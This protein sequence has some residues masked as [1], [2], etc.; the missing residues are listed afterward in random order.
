[1]KNIRII[2]LLLLI[3][4]G[5][6]GMGQSANAQE[7]TNPLIG[8]RAT[9]PHVAMKSGQKVN[10]DFVM[11][12]SGM[13]A[14]N[15]N[16]MLEVTP[17]LKS[18]S[19]T[20]SLE[21]PSFIISGST[22]AIV[23]SRRGRTADV[24]RTRT[25][26]STYHYTSEVPFS[27]WLKDASLLL[28]AKQYG[29]ADCDLGDVTLNLTP[30]AL[31][32]LYQPKYQFEMLVPPGEETKRRE[33]SLTAQIVFQVG[34]SEFIKTLGNNTA[35]LKRIDDKHRELTTNANLTVD[36]LALTGYASP[37]GGAEF[38]Q[39]LSQRRVESIADQLVRNYSRFKGNYTS[40][41]MGADWSGLRAAVAESNMAE[42][43]SILKIIDE[44]PEGERTAAL[45]QLNGG[46]TYA[47]L[48]REIYPP[49]RRTVIT[50]SFIVK[51]F[52][53]QEAREVIKTHPTHLSLA[54]INLVANSYP[55][56]SNERYQTWV[57]A[58]K[59][60]P[61]AVEPATNAA[62]IDIEARRYAQA[63]RLLDQYKDNPKLWNIL[64]IAYAY[65]EQYEE[66]R[67][68][69]ER[70]AQKGSADAQHNLA[71]LV[72]FLEDNF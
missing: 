64:G 38:N 39:N 5:S 28:Y 72:H 56:G 27:P 33:E 3:V 43:E 52:E 53:L 30:N 24:V 40:K 66:A 47:L 57:T 48:L 51:G 10:V 22:R 61:M 4:A 9:T 17:V 34:R 36:A 8:I 18:N 6:I 26:G 55:E 69:L 49:L 71:E 11:D 58:A 20:Q 63:V 45:K 12:L 65:N 13:P 2:S 42:K 37:E 59:A 62:V 14:L 21:L 46:T 67:N 23:L 50:F 32:P 7:H 31:V 25:K 16:V 68:Y 41:A 70:A 29:C 35:E 19:A 54:E 44:R 15:R 1:M 60:F